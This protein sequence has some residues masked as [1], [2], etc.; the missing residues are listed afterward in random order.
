V[1][2][3]FDLLRLAD[4]NRSTHFQLPVT[5]ELSTPFDFLAVAQHFCIIRT[6][7]HSSIS[8]GTAG[9]AAIGSV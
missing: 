8:A 9:S 4:G 2:E 1:T 3:H 5:P 6:S 7:H